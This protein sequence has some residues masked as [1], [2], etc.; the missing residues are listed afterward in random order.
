MDDGIKKRLDLLGFLCPIP[1][2]ETRRVL[3]TCER[4]DKI[5]VIC[6]DQETLFDIPALCD[7]VGVVLE[8]VEEKSGE[9]RFVIINVTG[10]L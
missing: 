1:V 7:R 2:H 6:D 4:G 9:F 3:K 10:D 8:E 5:E